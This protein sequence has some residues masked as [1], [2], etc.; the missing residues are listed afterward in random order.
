MAHNNNSRRSLLLLTIN[1]LVF[2]WIRSISSEALCS[3]EMNVVFAV[4]G[5]YKLG[6]ANFRDI[7]S[8][9]YNL[10]ANFDVATNKT[11]ITTLAGN[12]T[13]AYK[14]KDDLNNATAPRFPNSSEAFLGKSLESVKDWL[15]SNDSRMDAVTIVVVITSQKSDDDVAIPAINLKNSN[16]TVFSVAIG[17]QVSL[18]QL[19]EIAS[20][21]NDH[22]LLQATNTMDLS[23]N[24]NLTLAKR[25][26]EVVDKCV[27]SP[28]SNHGNCT[29]FTSGYKC[30]CPPEFQG[31][32]CEIS[33]SVEYL[34][35]G[36][37]ADASQNMSSL[38]SENATYL[39]GD[40]GTRENAVK[41][42]ALEAAKNGYKLFVTRKN[43]CHSSADAH[44][45]TDSEECYPGNEDNK[46]YLVGAKCGDLLKD[47]LI[48]L[49]SSTIQGSSYNSSWGVPLLNGDYSWCPKEEDFIR[50]LKVDLGRETYLSK[51]TLQ[52]KKDSV[53][54][55]DNYCFG[56][57][58]NG[59]HELEIIRNESTCLIS[60]STASSNAKTNVTLGSGSLEAQ[61][62]SFSPWRPFKGDG[63]CLRVDVLRKHNTSTKVSILRE[64][65]NVITCNHSNARFGFSCPQLVD[66]TVAWCPNRTDALPFHH[67]NLQ[68]DL[69]RP[70]NISKVVVQGAKDANEWP[71]KFCLRYGLNGFDFKE[72]T[73]NQKEC[74]L[75]KQT[76]DDLR[77][78]SER[79][80]EFLVPRLVQSVSVQPKYATYG[81][82]DGYC[83]RTEMMGCV[84]TTADGEQVTEGCSHK[85]ARGK[86]CVFPFIYEGQM[87]YSCIKDNHNRPWCATTD[88]YDRD[89][90]WD[91]CLATNPCH[92][93]AC[94]N[95][96]QCVENLMEWSYRCICTEKY[97]GDHC[98]DDVDECFNSPC[99]DGGKCINENGDYR[100]DCNHGNSGKNCQLDCKFDKVDLGILIDGSASVQF[101]GKDNFQI[102]K[103]SIKTF[104]RT[105]NVSSDLTRVGVIVYST[106]A[107]VVFKLDS[108]TTQSDVEQAID[109]IRYPAGGTY[110]GKALTKASEDLFDPSSARPGNVSK[111]L[112]VLTDGVSTDDVTQPAAL[113][114]NINVVPYVVGIGSNYDLSQLEQIA[115]N[116]T[117]LVFRTEF[118]TI[119]ETFNRLRGKIC[120]D[121]DKC[122]DN[123]CR[124]GGVC[125]NNGL[126]CTCA[127]GFQGAKCSEDVRECS[128][129]SSSCTFGKH[130]TETF[131]GFE[132][133]C[134]NSS[135]YGEN[136]T[137]DCSNNGSTVL[138]LL[139]RG[140]NV[141]EDNIKHQIEFII[142]VASS[143]SIADVAVISYATDAD[144][145]IRPGQAS[146][147]TEFSETLRG[148]NYSMGY[149]KNLGA[150]LRKAQEIEEIYN[151][152]KPAVV[153]VMIMGKS[154]DE[155]AP[156]AAKLKQRSVTL[157]AVPL[158]NNY[159]PA[160]MNLL[161]S[162][163]P[164]DHILVTD[165]SNLKHF[166]SG[167]R[168]AVCKAWKPCTSSDCPSTHEC[169]NN[170]GQDGGF[171]CVPPPSVCEPNPCKNGGKCLA[172]G[173]NT[174]N[175]TC[176]AGIG[177]V[178]CTED[179]VNECD[180]A[181]CK[182]GGTC[183]DLLGA[184]KCNCT[185]KFSGKE[186]EIACSS[187]RFN[188][189][190]LVD[191]SGSIELQG[192]GNFQR[193]K[194]F[195]ISL[196][197]E[198]EIGPNQTN[199]ATVLYSQHYRIIHRLD[200]FYTLAGVENA[201]QGMDF[202]SD[203]TRTGQGLNVIRNDIL[204]NLGPARGDVPKIVV[205]LTDGLS[206][207]SIVGPARA[208]RDIGVTI[209][210]VG[211]GCCYY[212]P[213]LNEMATD[214]DQDHVFEAKFS[215]L[216]RIAGSLRENICSAIDVCRNNPC[217]NNGIC[218]SLANDFHCNC[219][220]S[221]TGKNCSI[222]VDECTAN[223][224]KCS[225]NQLCHNYP[226]GSR[227]LCSDGLYDHNCT[228]RC[229]ETKAD[230]LF[231]VDSSGSINQADKNN[232]QRIKDFIKGFV[233]AVVIGPNDT[234]IGLATF[235]SQ[236][237][238]RV[239]FN[240]SEYYAT[241]ELVNAV[242]SIPYDAGGTYTGAALS[243]IRTH[244]FSM[245]REG[246]PKI[247]IIL[248]DGKS[249][250][251]VSGPSKSL[252]DE[253]VHIVSIGVGNAVYSELADMASDN[254]NVFNAT[255]ESLFNIF[256]TLQE[257][258]CKVVQNNIDPCLS[259]P[260]QNKGKC[261]RF[262]NG[263]NCTC[264]AGFTGEI[265]D[266]IQE[267]NK[268]SPSP[269]LN[270][271]Q[272]KNTNQTF[273]CFCAR[274]Y[275]GNRCEFGCGFRELGLKIP[276][277]RRIPDKHM[278]SSSQRDTSHSAHRGRIGIEVMGT[279]EDGWCSSQ[280]DT[281]PFIQVFFEYL[282][283]ITE[284]ETEAVEDE[285]GNLW[286]E[287]YYVSTSN[288]TEKT[289][290]VNYTED[291]KT[292]IFKANTNISA[293]NV[294]L[295]GTS[296]HFVRIHPL[297]HTGLFACLRIA[298]YGCDNGG[299]FKEF[300]TTLT[301]RID[302]ASFA[303]DPLF[304]TRLAAIP[305][306]VFVFLLL[307]SLLFLLLRLRKPSSGSSVKENI[308][309]F[310]QE[311]PQHG[312]IPLVPT[313][314]VQSLSMELGEEPILQVE[315]V[316]NTTSN[317]AIFSYDNKIFSF[318]RHV[319][320]AREGQS[321][322][323]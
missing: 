107:T 309:R 235:S 172:V 110:T 182:N 205:V 213:E 137:K 287:S 62:L 184:F 130:C 323:L 322:L 305:V 19:S 53:D 234:R 266:S 74:L 298:M 12:E 102:I 170:Y 112:V 169:K 183:R 180:S 152:S 320:L 125:Q 255:F 121:L 48:H 282:T 177:G 226:G 34:E 72:L 126:N 286:V 106:N 176:P 84:T 94:L 289:T 240:F 86:C 122:A 236:N 68:L 278:T 6:K 16:V 296:A 209:F 204:K 4:E 167:T 290:F 38:E 11:W 49:S 22:H 306:A 78:N 8:F 218:T 99:Q 220:S 15:N 254:K 212:K 85:T 44:L 159:N 252:R 43:A 140:K 202:P 55:P 231:L 187:Q 279:W 147:L 191:G 197:R 109:N 314:E 76:N 268:C 228:I 206:K 120:Q 265:C 98:E 70:F 237:S 299:D 284:I 82:N 208:L 311:P 308:V 95:G 272:C 18:G 203:G 63:L 168:D 261:K 232:Y 317:D 28:C 247:L 321:N 89:K 161:V 61:Y 60:L 88:N 31:G 79:T 186:C 24:F 129:A 65:G 111:I 116:A 17:S 215:D 134:A 156:Y 57:T 135:L 132:C 21:P 87:K 118:N 259:S 181:P 138:F 155:E 153:V 52:G 2:T 319:G 3:T 221:W 69:G 195:L 113:L 245:A 294:S 219:T 71:Y 59:G 90:L 115:V 123:P 46:V 114:K 188:L 20:N 222:D 150:A 260:C 316:N 271:G 196:V 257:T 56:S 151:H 160:E 101:Y 194:D 190:F 163:P 131:G 238:F 207:D 310:E 142:S 66:G 27:S 33:I 239:R 173:Y 117:D 263:F 119:S 7:F 141:G 10:S 178:N 36:C 5:S 244:L 303:K 229:N 30:T 105:F 241:H 164:S 275:Y 216:Q 243:T 108:Y 248:T 189:V 297:S 227:C 273:R 100:C 175:C 92:P 127:Q 124:F 179:I 246:I 251:D 302:N 312:A 37:V 199:V 291:G 267:P 75:F 58:V 77:G 223:V 280:T 211:V 185:E 103:D 14:T 165:V 200:T 277:T 230:V 313:Y 210:S 276:N 133:T 269:C 47:G 35:L 214:P 50:K 54:Y 281:T 171:R 9:I 149:M 26:C 1:L 288:S 83:V 104:I 193:S 198:F 249:E 146:N 233:K 136:C 97:T 154:N 13:K 143:I 293:K 41:K 250:D 39:D 148:A 318:D 67:H 262:L 93:K 128:N 292:R 158:D 23:Q 270:G 162:N 81:T 192:K 51:V 242:Q 300:P 40:F 64:A 25:I 91:N 217:E 283:N 145:V 315:G 144:I 295:H 258:V 32:N 166:V 73:Q 253:G 96:G 174:Y 301:E 201:I 307:G 274:G 225:E 224:T 304:D 29:S 80:R 256:D 157:L 264:P 285:S 45:K 42:C 139:D